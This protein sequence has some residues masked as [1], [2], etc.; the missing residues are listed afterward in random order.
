M[1]LRASPVGRSSPI[2][3]FKYVLMRLKVEKLLSL[4]AVMI[5]NMAIIC[6]ILN[7]AVTKLLL[8]SDNAST[9]VLGTVSPFASLLVQIHSQISIS[10]VR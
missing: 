3:F 10:A 5:G 4:V 2:V 9:T 7:R 1:S 6:Y 8:H